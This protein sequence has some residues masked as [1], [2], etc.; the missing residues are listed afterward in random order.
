MSVSVGSMSAGLGLDMSEFQRGMQKATE[1]ARSNSTLMS[2]E[3]KRTSREGAES[4]RLIDE[5]IGVH[6]SRPL[7]R[8]LTQEFPGL[9]KGLQA[10][11][12]VGVTGALVAVGIEAIR[13]ISDGIERAGQSQEKLG[14]AARNSQAVFEDA[15]G[16]I[17]KKIGEV[18]GLPAAGKFNM[19]GADE[20]R[21]SIDAVAQALEREQKAV[22][23]AGSLTTRVWLG[24]G[25]VL[26]NLARGAG[27]LL[28][29]KLGGNLITQHFDQG[30]QV[31]ALGEAFATMK[32]QLND[33]LRSDA[34]TG[35]HT[36]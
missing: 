25:D 13:K 15:L 18:N 10:V 5:A 33:A 32:E 1:V 4:L 36:A 8:I 6:I 34:A 30:D 14:E 7:A 3:M 2:A 23:E 20:A 19:E 35:Q 16:G 11:L 22:E 26:S 17:E 29:D 27:L 31:K 12:G 21:H 9:A 28:P 24:V